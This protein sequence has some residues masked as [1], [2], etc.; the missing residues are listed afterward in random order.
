MAVDFNISSLDAWNEQNVALAKAGVA[1]EEAALA[2]RKAVVDNFASLGVPGDLTPIIMEQ[3]DKEVLNEVQKFDEEF[4]KFV[5]KNEKNQQ[6]AVEM[7]SKL[8]GVVGRMSS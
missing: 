6:D 5:K 7:K 2:L 1:M 4:I 8:A 3:Y